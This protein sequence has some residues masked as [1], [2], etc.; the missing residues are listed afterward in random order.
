MADDDAATLTTQVTTAAPTATADRATLDRANRLLKA[1]KATIDDLKQQLA[2]R[3]EEHEQIKQEFQ[4]YK[5]KAEVAKQQSASEIS[6]LSDVNLKYK[7]FNV[8]SHD[9]L[10]ELEA[11]RRRIEG[12]EENRAKTEAENRRLTQAVGAMTAQLEECTRQSD[13][14]RTRA[15]VLGP[16]LLQS[17][18]QAWE[19]DER[20]LKAELAAVTAQ[21]DAAEKDKTEALRQLARLTATKSDSVDL[22]Y[23]RDILL[24]YLVTSDDK[25]RQAIETAIMA[26]L[27]FSAEDAERVRAARRVWKM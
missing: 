17:R 4:R 3:A 22:A 11:C 24:K 10:S 6:R 18:A 5:V 23:L 14:W 15:E 19:R 13:E 1:A 7:Q 12:L 26:V 8:S 27:R 2:A 9:V 20:E 16:R 21:R 25:A